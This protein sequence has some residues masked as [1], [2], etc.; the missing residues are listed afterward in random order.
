[1]CWLNWSRWVVAGVFPELRHFAEEERHEVWR[2][3]LSATGA[4]WTYAL[5]VVLG[6]CFGTLVML[7]WMVPSGS[8]IV[9]WLFCI[10]V[11]LVACPWVSAILGILIHRRAIRAALQCT[12]R[13][14]GLSLCR[15]CAYD[16]RGCVEGTQCPEC[17][18]P[19]E[20][21]EIADSAGRH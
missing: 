15:R 8:F 21:L 17:G 5:L 1:M 9:T 2:C 20:R 7:R 19:L 14:K 10:I 3:S 13:A 11:V 16:L 4:F 18:L 12:L 6:M